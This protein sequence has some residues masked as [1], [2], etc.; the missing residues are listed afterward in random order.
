LISRAGLVFLHWGTYFDPTPL[1]ERYR[2]VMQQTL[3]RRVHISQRLSNRSSTH[4]A[5]PLRAKT[6]DSGELLQLKLT[7]VQNLNFSADFDKI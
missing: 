4:A 2:L 5:S 3:W 7:L 1:C 6:N